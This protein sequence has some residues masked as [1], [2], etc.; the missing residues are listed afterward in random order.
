MEN[1][2]KESKLFDLLD[3]AICYI[4]QIADKDSPTLSY[5]VEN[6]EALQEQE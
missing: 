1:I 5:L 2:T 3:M 6:F 4:E